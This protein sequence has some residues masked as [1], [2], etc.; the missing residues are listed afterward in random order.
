MS[1]NGV[2]NRKANVLREGELQEVQWLSVQVGEIIRLENN[3]QV[4][5]SLFK[6]LHSTVYIHVK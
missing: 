5:V 2:N 3:D 4:P 1:D 6:S